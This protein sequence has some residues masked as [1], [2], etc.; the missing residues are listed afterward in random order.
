MW[1]YNRARFLLTYKHVGFATVRAPL[2]TPKPS[3]IQKC[4]F[5]ISA[6]VLVEPLNM[7]VLQQCVPPSCPQGY[8]RSPNIGFTQ[9]H[10]SFLTFQTCCLYNSARFLFDPKAVLD[11]KLIV[12]HQCALPF[13][14]L[15]NLGFT[16]VRAS[17]LTPT[18]SSIPACWFYNSARLL[19]DSP[20]M[21]VLQQC[22]PPF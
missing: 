15:T 13:G 18:P 12:L 20:N 11:P 7:V 8:S 17:F 3:W 21:L 4:W 10:A 19:F 22:A 16:T 14:P 5:Y 2:S 6:H 1:F 9:V